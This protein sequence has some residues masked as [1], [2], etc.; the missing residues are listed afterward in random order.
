MVTVVTRPTGTI[1]YGRRW[2]CHAVE[3]LDGV[4][5]FVVQS[6]RAVGIRGWQ[7]SPRVFFDAR[8]PNVFTR[9][10]TGRKQIDRHGRFVASKC[11]IKKA[12][13]TIT[14]T[15]LSDEREMGGGC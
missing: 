5:L 13:C 11:D 8:V 3:T 9:R 10:N 4:N 1:K 15:R 6:V 7:S 2:A 14:R 12:G